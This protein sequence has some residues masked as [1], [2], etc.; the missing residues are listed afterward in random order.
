MYLK[1]LGTID[2]YPPQPFR[3]TTVSEGGWQSLWSLATGTASGSRS[4]CL[5]PASGAVQQIWLWNLNKV[6]GSPQNRSRLE[7]KLLAKHQKW[8]LDTPAS[9]LSV[10]LGPSVFFYLC[11]HWR[12]IPS[13]TFLSYPGIPF[14]LMQGSTQ[15]RLLLI[16]PTTSQVLPTSGTSAAATAGRAKQEVAVPAAMDPA[17]RLR[18]KRFLVLEETACYK[19]WMLLPAGNQLTQLLSDERTL[20]GLYDTMYA[21]SKIFRESGE[22]WD[23]LDEANQALAVFSQ[24]CQAAKNQACK[25]VDDELQQLLLE[26][27]DDWAC[28][29]W[30]NPMLACVCTCWVYICCVLSST[31]ASDVLITSGQPL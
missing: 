5:T 28:L 30:T 24:S 19:L 15:Q 31:Q 9:M 6:N 8:S 14:C 11:S 22:G 21:F 3:L 12:F 20:E 17:K 2:E 16:T 13:A 7:P 25:S 26:F 27:G 18:Y 1:A 4:T 29:V 23:D 10:H